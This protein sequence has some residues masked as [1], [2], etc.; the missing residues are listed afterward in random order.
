MASKQ[1]SGL[2]RAKV[3]IGVDEQGK[4]IYKYVSGRTHKELE[5][6]RQQTIAYYIDG[7]GLANDVLFAPYA[8]AWYHTTKE[9]NI[10]PS[11]RAAYRTA[12]NRYVLP[13]FGERNLRAIRP[14]DLQR[15]YAETNAKSHAYLGIA[16][17]V[18]NGVFRA[19]CADQILDRNPL[20]SVQMPRR[21]ETQPDEQRADR[22]R[23][24]TREERTRIEQLCDREPGALYVAL[25][26]YLGLRQAEAAGLRWGD[27]DWHAGVVHVQR[28]V[29][30]HN[31]LKPTTPKTNAGIRDVP[32][33]AR[34]AAILS[35]LRGLPDVYIL[36]NRRGHVVDCNRRSDIWREMVNVRCNIPDI[37]AHALRHNYITMCWEAGIDVY[38]TARFVGHSNIATTLNI[39]THLSKE[40]ELENVK[41][42]QRLF[43][44][45]K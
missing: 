37:T 18:L 35:P 34:L 2:Y 12:F 16:K 19:A 29:D 13:A 3:K 41:A 22:H 9:P 7:T 39:Y 4:A 32:L 14:S 42:V 33:P 20:D 27:I 21:I 6:A 28:S 44:C 1:K 10:K 26:Y 31:A 43:D 23:A 5:A 38:A 11:T 30:A 40:R 45:A 15:F 24:L 36:R 8:I 17:T 25:L